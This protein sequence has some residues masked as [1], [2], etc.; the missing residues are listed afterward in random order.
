MAQVHKYGNTQANI[1][2]G[3]AAHALEATRGL[4]LD[5]DCAGQGKDVEG[6]HVTVRYGLIGDHKAAAAYLAKQSP[7]EVTLGE[8]EMFPATEHSDGAAVI[9][10][11]VSSV[12]L[13][14]MN[15]G[16]AEHAHFKQADF[17]YSPHATVAYVKPEKADQYIGIPITKGQRFIVDN[18]TISLCT[19]EQIRVEL[20]GKPDMMFGPQ[21]EPIITRYNEDQPRDA[22]GRFGSGGGADKAQKDL[23]DGYEKVFP[24]TFDRFQG[25]LGRYGKT[26]GR[27]K[28]LDSIKGKME[29]RYAGKELSALQDVVGMRV[30]V[31]DMDTLRAAVGALSSPGSG[32]K[33]L[34]HDDKLAG[35]GFYR[36]YHTTIDSMGTNE[37]G[38]R[39]GEVQIRTQRQSDIASWGH[40]VA[41][42]GAFSK[43]EAVQNYA[44]AVSNAAWELDNGR[45]ATYPNAPEALK[46]AGL[47][48]DHT[49]HYYDHWLQKE[50]GNG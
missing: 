31:K 44:V 40:D 13:H 47:E 46:S 32:F 42:K 38:E 25:V 26:E 20:G 34:E 45:P 29:G 19:G 7:F 30:T 6:N 9:K 16:L 3:P 48:F 18:I 50:R 22:D 41:Y 1:P 49:R 17:A 39:A 43:D 10:V 28:D 36:G 15:A 23:H 21:H 27:V 12:D 24:Q 8:T 5:D 37:H 2:S 33:I 14:R 35:Q 4:I 11:P